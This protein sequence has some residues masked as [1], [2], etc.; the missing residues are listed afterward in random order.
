MIFI[1]LIYLLIKVGNV[2]LK[3]Q[4]NKFFLGYYIIVNLISQSKQTDCAVLLK[5][6]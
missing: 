6:Q 3:D 2:C 1:N 5:Q 4:L